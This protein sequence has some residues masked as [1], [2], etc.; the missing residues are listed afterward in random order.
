MVDYSVCSPTAA[1]KTLAIRLSS[2]IQAT[3]TDPTHLRQKVVSAKENLQLVGHVFVFV[4]GGA[5]VDDLQSPRPFPPNGRVSH[6]T[7]LAEDRQIYPSHWAC[8][9][10]ATKQFQFVRNGA[11]KYTNSPHCHTY[12]R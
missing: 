5:L 12:I 7:S 6:Q 11:M 10:S 2:R 8:A 1:D 3:S 9:F 4:V